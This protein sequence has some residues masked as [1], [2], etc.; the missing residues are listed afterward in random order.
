MPSPELQESTF[1][2]SDI[3]QTTWQIVV[4]TG[5]PTKRTPFGRW[6]CS[7][8]IVLDG[9]QKKVT[10]CTHKHPTFRAAKKCALQRFGNVRGINDPRAVDDAAG[11]TLLF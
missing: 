3:P 8:I 11:Q 5:K 1:D 7:R 10:E 2:P 6:Y 9:H 4:R